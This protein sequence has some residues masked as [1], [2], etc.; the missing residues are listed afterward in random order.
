MKRSLYQEMQKTI[1]GVRVMVL[2]ATSSIFQLYR[3]GLI[4]GEN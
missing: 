2:N 4:V 1:K 3:G